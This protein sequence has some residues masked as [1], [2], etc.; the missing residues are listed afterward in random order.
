[1]T[2]AKDTNSYVTRAEAD[3][4]LAD[5]LDVPAWVAATD[6]SKDQAL[7]TATSLLDLQSYTGYATSNTQPLAFPRVGEYFDARVGAIVILDSAVVPN[8]ILVAT[9]ELAVHLLNNTGVLDDTGTVKNITV[10][11]IELQN[12]RNPN[13]IPGFVDQYIRPLFSVTARTNAW[14]RAN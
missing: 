10:G 6:P 5:R 11:E 12:I 4:Y 2:L 13:K 3:T 14:W 1:M 8:R 7:I 9:Y